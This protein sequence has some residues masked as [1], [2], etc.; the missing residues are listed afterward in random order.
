MRLCGEM[1]ERA[2]SLVATLRDSEEAIWWRLE[3]DFKSLA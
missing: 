3:K 2:F 1:D